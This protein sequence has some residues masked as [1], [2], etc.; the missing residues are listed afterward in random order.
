MAKYS[1]CEGTCMIKPGQATLSRFTGLPM[2]LAINTVV[3]GIAAQ[4]SATIIATV[5]ITG[6]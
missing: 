6:W 5:V 2:A 4:R 1:V 3:A